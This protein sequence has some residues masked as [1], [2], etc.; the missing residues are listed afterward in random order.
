M[1]V[2]VDDMSE[3]ALAVVLTRKAPDRFSPVCSQNFTG[4]QAG[5]QFPVWYLCPAVRP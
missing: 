1:A 3:A 4:A 2:Y 5:R